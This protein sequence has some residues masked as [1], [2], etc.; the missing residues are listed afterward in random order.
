MVLHLTLIQR[1]K[2]P[3]AKKSKP[4][5]VQKLKATAKKPLPVKIVNDAPKS[6]SYAE[7]DKK[8]R[9]EDDLRAL[10]RA[11]EIEADKSRMQAVKNIAKE[12]KAMLDKFC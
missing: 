11:K 10:K 6:T 12:E 5:P 1:G 4:L 8:W 7:E 3:M 9:A 2:K